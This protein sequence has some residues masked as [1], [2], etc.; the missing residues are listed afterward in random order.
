M[1]AQRYDGA[2]A[3]RGTE[4]Q[5][6]VFTADNQEAPLLTCDAGGSFVVVGQSRGQDG[7]YLGIF[8]RRYDANGARSETSF[9]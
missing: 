6:N 8:G 5:V 7:D 1:F 4:L 3:R 9:R 2:G